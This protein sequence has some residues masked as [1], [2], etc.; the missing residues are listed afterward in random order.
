MSTAGIKILWLFLCVLLFAGCGE[1]R[2][3]SV[4]TKS[5][6]PF[7]ILSD[8]IITSDVSIEPGVVIELAD[9][10]SVT[11]RGSV[12]LIGSQNERVVVQPI[13]SSWEYLKFEGDDCSYY[14]EYVTI[15]NGKLLFKTASIIELLNVNFNNNALQQQKNGLLVMLEGGSFYGDSINMISNNTGEGIVVSALDNMTI[16]NSVFTDVNDA[17]ELMV[18]KSGLI[19][20]CSFNQ[21]IHDDGVDLDGCENVVISGNK[22]TGIADNC[23]EVGLDNYSQS[24][25]MGILIKNNSFSNSKVGV[26]SKDYSEIKY[27]NNTFLNCEKNIE[28]VDT[29]YVVF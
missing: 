25:S 19:L 13:N 7:Q 12:S 15:N 9:S 1:Q 5:Q 18:C 6:S 17:V 3:I 28:I 10:V 27:D 29:A 20:D 22:F 14:F 11:F 4:I 8:T 16:K 2:S 23:I 24:F 21:C 26:F